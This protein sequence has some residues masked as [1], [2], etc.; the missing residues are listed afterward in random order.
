MAAEILW[1]DVATTL[2]A[3]GYFKRSRAV[4]PGYAVLTCSKGKQLEKE[5]LRG[6]STCASLLSEIHRFSLYDR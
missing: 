2:Q 4:C 6:V 5:Q 1:D 3:V